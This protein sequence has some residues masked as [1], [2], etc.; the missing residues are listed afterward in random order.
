M[1]KIPTLETQG[2]GS[3]PIIT[4]VARGG[5]QVGQAKAKAAKAWA[6]MFGDLAKLSAASDEED[7]KNRIY[8]M[9]NP[10]VSRLNVLMGDL[11]RSILGSRELNSKFKAAIDKEI[12][13]FEDSEEGRTASRLFTSTAYSARFHPNVVRMGI[14]N[15]VNRYVNLINKAGQNYWNKVIHGGPGASPSMFKL[16]VKDGK[17]FFPSLKKRIEELT[18]R[19]YSDAQK[20]TLSEDA[21]YSTLGNWEETTNGDGPAWKF[22][23]LEKNLPLDEKASANFIRTRVNNVADGLIEYFKREVTQAQLS[24]REGHSKVEDFA[25]VVQSIIIEDGKTKAKTKKI[26]FYEYISTFI[27]ANKAELN[28]KVGNDPKRPTEYEALK[29]ELKTVNDTLIRASNKGTSNSEDK[30]KLV[31]GVYRDFNALKAGMS[32]EIK[33]L[34]DRF[35]DG[36]PYSKILALNKTFARKIAKVES[37]FTKLGLKGDVSLTS[38]RA[39]LSDAQ[40]SADKEILQLMNGLL[41]QWSSLSKTDRDVKKKEEWDGLRNSLHGM[42]SQRTADTNW[43]N[44]YETR[45]TATDRKRFDAIANEFLVNVFKLTKQD[46][47]NKRSPL[48]GRFMRAKEAALNIMANGNNKFPPNHEADPTKVWQYVLNRPGKSLLEEFT[49]ISQRSYLIGHVNKTKASVGFPGMDKVYKYQEKVF[50]G[51]AANTIQGDATWETV[52]KNMLHKLHG[53]STQAKLFVT[54]YV[55]LLTTYHK[56]KSPDGTMPR[57]DNP[58][59]HK[60]HDWFNGLK[61]NKLSQATKLMNDINMLHST[62]K[63]AVSLE[64]HKRNHQRMRR[65]DKETKE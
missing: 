12:A 64:R 52:N 4:D 18:N 7:K 34:K 56:G 61:G 17:I 65:Q 36:I 60:I 20:D 58:K 32:T 22:V 14:G 57:P 16:D 40:K 55:E 23:L 24:E 46:L 35:P 3:K 38:L 43:K 53:V 44:Y 50:G 5:G 28:Y 63:G 51:G 42:S 10:A 8:A 15:D 29:K 21:F 26:S 37:D 47:N 9:V 25:N 48:V 13:G 2:P 39:P 62:W 33:K 11:S 19:T 49:L 54:E 6:N 41:T 59:L 30:L 31:A 27:E 1:P 45:S